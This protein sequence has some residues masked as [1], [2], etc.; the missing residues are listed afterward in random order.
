MALLRLSTPGFD[1]QSQLTITQFVIPAGAGATFAASNGIAT[2]TTNAAHG[3]TLN[4]SAGVPPNYFV[5]FGGS[6]SALTGTGILVGNIFRI[7]AIPSTTTFQIYTSITAAT[8]TALTVI[9]VFFPSF[10]ASPGSLYSGPQPSMTV[11]GVTTQY[12]PPNLESAMVYAQQA[13]N[14]AIRINSDN[15]FS[16]PLDQL[17]TPAAGTPSTAP[18][19]T[20]VLGTASGVVPMM[21]NTSC[22]WASGTTATSTYSV[23]N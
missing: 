7:L 6:T 17:S 22:I 18:V 1:Y 10:T 12:P 5:T 8:V 20:T 11:S 21:G 23:L 9:P 16:F 13:A 19:W 15:T 2:I 3:L 4:P 14:C